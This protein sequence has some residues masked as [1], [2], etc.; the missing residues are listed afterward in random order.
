LG[1][2]G[3]ASVTAASTAG[4]G[5][6]SG[7]DLSVGSARVFFSSFSAVS[8]EVF[9]SGLS[10]ISGLSLGDGFELAEVGLAVVEAA[11]FAAAVAGT[12]FL[13]PA[14]AGLVAVGL[15]AP[16]VAVFLAAGLAVVVVVVVGLAGTFAGAAVFFGPD[17]VGLTVHRVSN[18]Q[19]K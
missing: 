17:T 6:S 15:V 16:T 7:S 8:S 19:G 18:R 13:A 5:L 12:V 14:G 1:S 9:C 11:F 2:S 4:C 3:T 10:A